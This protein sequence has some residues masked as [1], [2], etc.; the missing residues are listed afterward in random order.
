MASIVGKHIAETLNGC[1]EF[2]YSAWRQRP[3]S[4]KFVGFL[5]KP[6]RVFF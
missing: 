4:E 2:H 5:I 3:L 1:E 6:V